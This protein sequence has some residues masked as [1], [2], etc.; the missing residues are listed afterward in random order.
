MQISQYHLLAQ[1]YSQGNDLNPEDA[2]SLC[3]NPV[4]FYCNNPSFTGYYASDNSSL[5][6][7]DNVGGN[8]IDDSLCGEIPVELYCSDSSYVGYYNTNTDG[9][10]DFA[11]GHK[12]G[13]IDDQVTCGDLVDKY[14]NDPLYQGYY[15]TNTVENPYIGNLIHNEE[16]CGDLATFYCGDPEYLGYYLEDDVDGQIAFGSHIDN[17]T[18]YCFEPIDSYCSDSTYF[19]YYID[20]SVSFDPYI[21]NIKDDSKCLTLINPGC[22]DETMFNYDANANVNQFSLSDRMD[23]CYPIVYGCLDT[24]AYNFNNYYSN[25]N[26]NP[27][28]GNPYNNGDESSLDFGANMP[29]DSVYSSLFYDGSGNGINV[30]T[31]LPN[32]PSSLYS[33]G[34]IPSC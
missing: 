29:Q 3:G 9:I 32:D 1:F 8:I 20:Y 2:E 12:T 25:L 19:E 10:H 26:I 7:K 13:N 27:A 16:A 31:S 15:S 4:S 6:M 23:P 17:S 34:C 30:N 22:M 33:G 11:L 5:T 24:S 18:E 14:C 21:G 28:T